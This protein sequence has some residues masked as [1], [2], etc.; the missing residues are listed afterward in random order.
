MSLSN[1][2][3]KRALEFHIITISTYGYGLSG[4]D[5]IFIELAKR[6][7]KSY[8]VSIYAW[9]EG[10]NIC[11]R[12]GVDKKSLTLWSAYT[13]AHL[14]F[15]INY[16]ARIII[17]LYKTSQL[18]LI[19]SPNTIVYS[20]SEFWQDSLPALI[21][22]IRFP[23]VKWIAAWYQT[24]PNPFTGYSEG[25]RS[26]KYR[27]KALL[28][29]LVQLP[30]KPIIEKLA[31]LVIVNNENEK[32]EFLDMSKKD[33]VFV[34]LGGVDLDKIKSYAS[35]HKNIDKIYDGVFMGRF[36]PQKGVVE[37]IDIW[38]IVV[39]SRPKAI[40][41]MIGDGPLMNDVK[42]RIKEHR[43]ENNVKLFGYLFDGPKKYKIFSQ[44]KVVLHPAF[45]DSGGMASAEAMAFGLPGVSFDLI[46]LRT[47]YPYG[48]V[49][50][51]IGDISKFSK[52]VLQLL[53]NE[54]FYKKIRL[55]ASQ[56][57]KNYWD[58]NLK[59]KSLIKKLKTLN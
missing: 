36:H 31:D 41:V 17:A 12:E 50:V 1:L 9:E 45:Y 13:T 46:A 11:I 43:L 5:R 7:N 39:E 25:S 49:K 34:M 30:I 27:F 57:I 6:L 37:L 28:Y 42:D 44:S 58:W 16:F 22:R 33:K 59:A 26:I 47:Y 2:R 10:Y 23:K 55:Q 14:G 20:A 18:K 53:N 15:F 51:P 54:Q 29:W 38:R 19:N 40:L 32:K 3:N 35:K 56:L 52:E 48:M 8:P 21:L 24:A 4:G